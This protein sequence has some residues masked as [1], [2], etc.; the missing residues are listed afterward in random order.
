M[1]FEESLRQRI[2]EFPHGSP[3][4]NLFKLVLGEI[5]QRDKVTDEICH[6]IVKKIINGNEEVMAMVDENG[7]PLLADDDSRRVQY[8]HENK[9]LSEL[10]PKYLNSVQIRQSLEDSGIDLKSDEK[11]GKAIGRAI[12]H[13]NKL[14][15]PFE[16]QTVKDV[17]VEIR[18]S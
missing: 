4:K 2:S 9:I 3:D 14:A 18:N 10:L 12:E 5:Q 15:L 11:D 6:S 8:T 17:V 16:G 1:T 7:K 13:F